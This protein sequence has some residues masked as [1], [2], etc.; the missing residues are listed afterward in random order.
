RAVA[1][2]AVG[3]LDGQAGDQLGA[4]GT[5]AGLRGAALGGDGVAQG[6]ADFVPEPAGL[7]GGERLGLQRGGAEDEVRAGARTAALIDLHP[8]L[9]AVDGGHL[10]PDQVDA[11]L[12]GGVGLVVGAVR[13]VFAAGRLLGVLLDGLLGR[14]VVR[15]RP[16]GVGLDVGRG[17]I[18]GVE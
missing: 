3:P 16:L 18:G 4:E 2:A 7:G 11:V 14:V 17:A 12:V 5:G 6:A 15:R 9:H 1:G 8:Q 10:Q 13:E